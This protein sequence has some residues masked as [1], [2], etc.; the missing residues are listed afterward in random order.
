MPETEERVGDVA[1][2]QE[3]FRE[4]LP[5]ITD[6]PELKLVL[7][8]TY[9]AARSPEKHGVPLSD[10]LRPEVIRSIVG[11]SSPEPAEV[12]L[13]RTVE[14]AVVDGAIFR[15]KLHIGRDERVYFLP[16]SASNRQLLGRLKREDSDVN[17]ELD[18]EA[19]A[20][21]SLYRPNIFALYEQHL[22]PLSP[23]LAEE[24]RDAERSYPRSWIEQAII[25]AV[26]YNKRNWRYVQ[27]VLSQWEDS[28]GPNGISR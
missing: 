28:G 26:H 17:A 3:F 22:G 24:L 6:A 27:R 16:V 19:Q 1:L 7:F 11:T 8:V 9:L 20:D 14:K 25:E 4:I 18:L 5:R 15:L 2:P 13:Q 10:L 21:V 12:R 23:L